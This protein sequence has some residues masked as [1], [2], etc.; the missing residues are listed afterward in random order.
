M[1]KSFLITKKGFER[2]KDELKHLKTVERQ[3]VAKEIADARKHGDF[4]ENAEYHAAKEKYAFI[5]NRIA[6]I[7]QRLSS[8]EVVDVSSVSGPNICFGAFVRLI[9]DVTRVPVT[10]QIVGED[11]ADIKRGL[12][13]CEAPL[14]KALIGKKEGDVI[15]FVTPNGEKCYAIDSVFYEQ[16][17]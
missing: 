6:K 2:L 1:P 7:E 13:S 12:L 8:V 14:A 5:E 4:S 11:E 15:E 10:Y 3:E 16:Q 17:T 9:D